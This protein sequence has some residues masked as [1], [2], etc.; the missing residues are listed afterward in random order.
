[1]LVTYPTGSCR[2]PKIS[3][4]LFLQG[5]SGTST[6]QPGTTLL[7]F[8]ADICPWIE[9]FFL[10]HQIPLVTFWDQECTFF[11]FPRSLISVVSRLCFCFPKGCSTHYKMESQISCNL[12]CKLPSRDNVSSTFIAAVGSLL[13]AYGWPCLLYF[14][15]RLNCFLFVFVANWLCVLAVLQERLFSSG[16]DGMVFLQ[17]LWV[18][19]LLSKWLCSNTGFFSWWGSSH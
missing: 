14:A 8:Q 2:Y 19:T 6:V 12:E 15:V 16:N 7:A 17:W 1:M 4:F 18:F 13:H 11:C 5:V 3:S 10:V 9:I